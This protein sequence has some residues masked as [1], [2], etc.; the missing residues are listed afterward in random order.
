MSQ[1]KWGFSRSLPFQA[2]CQVHRVI[3]SEPRITCVRSPYCT[4]HKKS[5]FFSPRHKENFYSEPRLLLLPFLMPAPHQGGCFCLETASTVMSYETDFRQD[6][7]S[8][9][10]NT[11]ASLGARH[12]Q[13]LSCTTYSSVLFR[14]LQDSPAALNTYQ[15]HRVYLHIPVLFYGIPNGETSNQERNFLRFC[16]ATYSK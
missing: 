10:Q 7:T 16:A 5:T 14:S 11:S 4:D 15:S 8:Q 12:C 1:R 2:F 6:G 13:R 9:E 3:F